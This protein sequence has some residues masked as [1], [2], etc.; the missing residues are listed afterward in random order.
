MG[1][2]KYPMFEDTE[3][4]FEECVDT[5]NE[6]SSLD[7]VSTTER[8]AITQLYELAKLF[9]E[10]YEELEPDITISSDDDDFE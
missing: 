9:K 2:M 1:P 7:R 4:D 10:R 8:Q 3:E 6:I 5:L